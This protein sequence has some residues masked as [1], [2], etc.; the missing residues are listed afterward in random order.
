MIIWMKLNAKYIW[1][2]DK[3]VILKINVYVEY[4]NY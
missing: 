4:S 3:N 2:I 1:T